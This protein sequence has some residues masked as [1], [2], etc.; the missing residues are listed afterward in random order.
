MYG[1]NLNT[2]KC[3]HMPIN[4]TERIHFR[5]GTEVPRDDTTTYLGTQITT[6]SR[7]THEINAR[8]AAARVT[9]N[10]LD[11]FWKHST[12]STH[13]KLVIYDMVIRAKLCYSLDCLAL[14]DHHLD[15]LQTFQ[16]KGLR[17]ILKFTTTFVDKTHSNDYVFKQANLAK[18]KTAQH[19]FS[20]SKTT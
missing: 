3:V 13:L 12:C 14:S 15:A 17:Q 19:P 16:L 1:L 20:Q 5:S 6:D 2:T 7:V 4:S 11:I 18:K 8:I 10:K 9:W